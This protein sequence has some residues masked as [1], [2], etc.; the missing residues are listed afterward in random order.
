MYVCSEIIASTYNIALLSSMLSFALAGSTVQ[1]KGGPPAARCFR[2]SVVS[3]LVVN[4]TKDQILGFSSVKEEEA[5]VIFGYA[6]TI[7]QKRGKKRETQIP[8]TF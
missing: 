5:Q 8:R 7:L 2:T 6:G 3:F 1:A 4:L